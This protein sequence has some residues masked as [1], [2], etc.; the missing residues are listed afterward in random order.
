MTTTDWRG[1]AVTNNDEDD[2]PIDE[3]VSRRREARSLLGNLLRPYADRF[4]DESSDPADG[5]SLQT[6][7]AQLVLTF[8]QEIGEERACHLAL[9]ELEAALG[10]VEAAHSQQP[11]EE[12]EGAAH[13]LP[14]E[15]L[16][17]GDVGAGDGTA[18]EDHRGRRHDGN[19]N[20]GWQHL[21]RDGQGAKA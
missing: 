4:L 20:V 14:V 3:S 21:E 5:A 2:L 16:M 11:D 10:V 17:L 13:E 9:Q 6:P 15:G 18:A 7:P 8:D 19:L 1:R 12:I